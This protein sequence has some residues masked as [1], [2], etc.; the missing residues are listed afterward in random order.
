MIYHPVLVQSLDVLE[1]TCP[2]MMI[3]LLSAQT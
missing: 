3:E 2:R 1:N